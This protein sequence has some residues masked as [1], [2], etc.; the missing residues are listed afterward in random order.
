MEGHSSS[1][2]FTRIARDLLFFAV[3]FALGVA[4][5][6]L[7]RN[8]TFWHPDDYQYLIQ[9]LRIDQSLSEIFAAAPHDNFQPVINFIFF[10]EYK[11]FGLTAWY[12]YLFNIFI[13]SLNAFLVYS[14]LRTLLADRTIALLSAFMFVFAVGNYG[15]A[16][17]VV[18]GVSDLIIT[19]L[20][21]LTMNFYIRNEINDRGRVRTGNF[22]L[23]MLFFALGLMSKATS[24][25][26]LGCML[27]FN[28]FYRQQSGRRIFDRNFLTI[29]GFSLLVLVAKLSL[30][31]SIPGSNDLQIFSW[32]VPKT[33]ASYL[34]R[35][36]FPIHYSTL[37]AD[38]GPVV[39]FTYQLASQIRLLIF[40][41]I[42]SYSV[43]GFVFGNRVIRFFIAWTYIVVTP[44]CFFRFPSD[45]LNIRYLYLVSVGFVMILASGTTLA[46]RLLYQKQWRRLLPFLVPV[47]FVLLSRFVVS[48][49]DTNYEALANSPRLDTV[50]E[51]FH[52]EYRRVNKGG[53]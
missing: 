17:M 2:N 15:K 30:L 9:A 43:F 5:F 49:L 46:A 52:D 13:H 33:L 26:V 42:V 3:L 16:V 40:M 29:A 1:N 28:M 20:T 25:S 23:T 41:C 34:V 8:N 53:L 6:A 51:Q 4:F 22:L 37:V 27:A 19:M 14:L 38:S 7:V 11:F 12:Y 18:S 47:F 32:S 31:G 39:K 45:W 21:L 24:F 10:L 50:K 48:K 35:M 36:V 44:F